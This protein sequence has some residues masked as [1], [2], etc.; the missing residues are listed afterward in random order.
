MP[1]DI[2]PGLKYWTRAELGLI[3]PSSPIPTAAKSEFYQHHSGGAVLGRSDFV[4]WWKEIQ[5]FHMVSNGWNDIGY[6]FG[7]AFDP[8]VAEIGHILEG[9]G[10][11]GVGAHTINHNTTGIGVCYLRNGQAGDAIKRASRWIYDESCKREKRELTKNCHADVYSTACAGE[12]LN[13]WVRE[14]MPT[15]DAPLV[16]VSP[17]ITGVA[18]GVAVCQD[19][20]WLAAS[21]GGVFSYGKAQFAGSAAGVSQH[22]IVGI[23]GKGDGSGYWLV[24]SDG[25]IFAYG[26]AQFYG[27]MGGKPLNKP[28]TGMTLSATEEGYYLVGADGGLFCFGDAEFLGTPA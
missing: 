21:D 16:P 15:P 24:A 5:R 4:A 17:H 23:A 19:G 8:N 27:S 7:V 18:V 25:G 28:I 22:P 9:R 26:S 12:D 6:N 20:Y 3:S 13:S 11:N 2:G 10:W 1:T 14:G